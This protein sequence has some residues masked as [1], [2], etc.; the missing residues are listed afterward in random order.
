MADLTHGAVD[1]L[2]GILSAAIKD[3]AELLSGVQGDIQFIRDEMDSMNGFLLHLTKSGDDHDDQQRA[4]MKQVRDIAYIAHDCIELYMRITPSHKGFWGYVRHI[5]ELVKTWW[6]R[7][8]LANR[9][10]DLKVRVRDIGERRQRYGVTVPEAKKGNKPAAV[11]H[12]AKGAAD[13]ARG[14]FLLALASLGMDAFLQA[15]ASVAMDDDDGAGAEKNIDIVITLLPGDLGDLRSDKTLIKDLQAV[16]LRHGGDNATICM[17]MEMLLRAL[18]VSPQ[19]KGRVSKE[20]VKNLVVAASSSSSGAGADLDLPKQVM[21][22][23]YSKLSRDYKSCLQY[24]TAFHEEKSISRTSLVRRWAAERLVVKEEKQSY[25]EAAEMC[26]TELLFRGFVY[27]VEY[28]AAGNKVKSCRM[29]DEVKNFVDGISK[30]ENFEGSRLPPHLDNQFRIRQ[31]VA[32][33]EKKLEKEKAEGASGSAVS[34]NICGVSLPRKQQGQDG[35]SPVSAASSKKLEKSID[36]QLK[37]FRSLPETYRVNVMD[38]GGCK[39]LKKRQLKSI[40]KLQTLKYLSLRNTDVPDLPHQIKALQL[41]ETLDIRQT[42]IRHSCTKHIN[43]LRKLKH[44]LAGDINHSSCDGSTPFSTVRMPTNISEMTDMEVLSCV[45][46]YR[47]SELSELGNLKKLRKL[48]VLLPGR[49]E[50]IKDLRQAISKMGG[51]L[52]SLSIWINAPCADGVSLDKEDGD[53]TFLHLVNLESLSITGMVKSGLPGWVD[54]GLKQLSKITLCNTPLTHGKLETLSNLTG[55]LCLRLHHGS[56]T[57]EELAFRANGFIALKFLLLESATTTKLTF[58][59]NSGPKLEKIVWSMPSDASFVTTVSA[60]GIEHLAGLKQVVLKGL[61]E[62]DSCPLVEKA[63]TK[64]PRHQAI[65]IIGIW[66]N[67]A[68]TSTT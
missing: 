32:K 43:N 50:D 5:P 4:W 66:K 11:L 33:Q 65:E 29:R 67:V 40:C 60:T 36:K 25:E 12:G 20:E 15:L 3:E 55:L 46:I 53:G 54:E 62:G 26:F 68:V 6:P 9:L 38:L 47:G 2:L 34:L 59:E 13:E 61:S 28:G 21:L 37:H 52:H 16:A 18:H 42:K 31:M 41:L 23:C 63:I 57:E 49:K 39:G 1:S 56:F 64:H 51:R 10:R 58:E 17:V 19:G 30:S 7:R 14:A 45:Q 24:L 8:R 27:P 48:G 35:K 44:L 22:L